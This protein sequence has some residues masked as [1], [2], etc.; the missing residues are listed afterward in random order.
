VR[1]NAFVTRSSSTSTAY[2]VK[3]YHIGFQERLFISTV[4]S[5]K[6][7][8][9]L[10]S[11]ATM[12]YIVQVTTAIATSFEFLLAT[13]LLA[14]F[15]SAYP[16]RFRSTLWR[17]GGSKGWNS[18]PSYRTYL[19]ANYQEVPPMPMIWDERYASLTSFYPT[20]D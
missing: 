7:S 13:T 15:A 20:H 3:E 11:K 16:D 14:L 18:D 2:N 5:L 19:W 1:K 17:E 8:F 10:W 12:V 6:Y 4:Q 9:R